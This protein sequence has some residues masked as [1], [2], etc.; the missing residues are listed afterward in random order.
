MKIK[1]NTKDG[2]LPSRYTKYAEEKDKYMGKPVV[3]FPIALE[4]VPA[5]T[6]S[7]ALT[8]ID[9]DAVPVCGFPWIHWIACDIDGATAEIPED[10]SRDRSFSMTQGKNSSCSKFLSGIDP[11]LQQGY[12]GPTPPDRNHDYTLAVYALDCGTLGLEEGFYLSD[13]YHKMEHHILAEASI[14]VCAEC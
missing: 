9:F 3:S 14:A 13:L 11:V 2:F 12:N 10:A 8:L 6:K 1:V 7:L 4:D 5:G